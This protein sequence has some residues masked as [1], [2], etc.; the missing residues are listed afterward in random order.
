MNMTLLRKTLPSCGVAAALCIATP[1][2]ADE[3]LASFGHVTEARKESS[4]IS[5]V[6]VAPVLLPYFNNAPAFGTPGTRTGAPSERTQL[7]GDWNG[8][9]AELARRG[10]F[11]DVYTTSAYSNVNSGGLETGDGFVQNLQ[12]S[13]NIDTA[14]AG[15]WSGGLLHVTLQSRYGDATGRTFNAGGSLP[16]YTGLLHPGPT[17]HHNTY[18]AEMFLVQGLSRQV[19]VVLGRISDIYIP[20]QTTFG[21]SYKYYFANFNFNKNPMTAGFYQPTAWSA[22]GIWAPSKKLVL[23]GGVLDPYSDAR[24]FSRNAFQKV[25]L[26][27]MAVTTYRIAGMPGSFGPAFNWSNAPK[28]DL[29]RPF[30]GLQPAEVPAAIGA[31]LGARSFEGLP[32]NRKQKSW[33]AIANAS[34]YLWLKDDPADVPAKLKGGEVLSGV[35]LFARA[36]YAPAQTNVVTRDASVALFA[37]GLLDARPYDSFGVGWYYNEI[38]SDFKDTIPAL[39]QGHRQARNESGTEVFYNLAITPAVRFIGSYQYIRHPLSAQVAEGRESTSLVMGR[40]TVAW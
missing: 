31:L 22:L 40:I 19:S 6:D 18:P 4:R 35:G 20:D 11:L 16:S 3:N 34:Q 21:D 32:V 2:R 29:A 12:T 10:V 36:G 13:L 37:H 5:L 30:T 25:N 15:G 24:T 23:A 28:T 8:A 38:S 9:R 14:R 7:A 27:L 39:T 33:F 1:A 17:Y 26:Y